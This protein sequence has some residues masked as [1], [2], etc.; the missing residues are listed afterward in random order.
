M[1]EVAISSGCF[2]NQEEQLE[3]SGIKTIEIASH[4]RDRIKDI[5]DWVEDTQVQ[6]F[7]VHAPCPGGGRDLNLACRKDHWPVVANLIRE[8]ME[9][10]KRFEAKYVVIH[11]FYCIPGQ[12]PS[13]DIQ[14]M[15]A[16]RRLF[17]NGGS[18]SEYIESTEYNEAKARAIENLK[19]IMPSLLRDF[20]G[21]RL[22]IENL[23]PRIGY[24]GLLIDDLVD[25]ASAFGGDMG[26]CLDLG[27]LTLTANALQR[28]IDNGI[29]IAHGLIWTTHI[30]QNFAGRFC[31]NQHWNESTPR[32]DL[33]EVDTHLPFT[34]RFRC[35]EQNQPLTVSSDNS[36]FC[37][38]L[39]GVAQYT[40]IKEDIKLE[41]SVEV[42]LLLSKV[43]PSAYRVFEFDSRYAPLTD[44]I[45]EYHLGFQGNHPRV[46]L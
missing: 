19:S 28:K 3:N 45:Q 30:H 36:A 15:A 16:L 27:H 43:S 32:P 40:N 23:N 35:R 1:S 29:G 20:P 14:R 4:P 12:F 18:I 46:H 17:A 6:V 24:G 37:D 11:A 44:I 31:V 33:Q 26:I 34:S 2:I 5:F 13:N 10:A 38:I 7:S 39:E 9:T 41:G 42:E 25:I 21:Q 22:V 8:S